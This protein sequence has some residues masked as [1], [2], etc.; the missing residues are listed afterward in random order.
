MGFQ[1]H[2]SCWFVDRFMPKQREIHEI[3][4]TNTKKPETIRASLFDE[5][6][7]SDITNQIKNLKSKISSQHGRLRG[8][9]KSMPALKGIYRVVR[10][11]PHESGLEVERFRARPLHPNDWV[12]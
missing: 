6:N 8:Q 5:I 4:R 11:N 3:T 9:Q 12:E 1:E 10:V 7:F 2:S